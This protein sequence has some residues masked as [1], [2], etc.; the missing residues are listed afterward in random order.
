M[1]TSKIQD[2]AKGPYQKHLECFMSMTLEALQLGITRETWETNAELL[3][4]AIKKIPK[5]TK[6]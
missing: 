2:M 6:P 4:K 1:E 3:L 5:E